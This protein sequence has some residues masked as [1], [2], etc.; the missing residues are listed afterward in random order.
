M[1]P[2]DLRDR[3]AIHQRGQHRP[4]HFQPPAMTQKMRAKLAFDDPAVGAD[5][6]PFDMGRDRVEIAGDK[7]D[8][9]ALNVDVQQINR[10]AAAQIGQGPAVQYLHILASCRFGQRG[11]IGIE[12]RLCPPVRPVFVM[13]RKDRLAGPGTG[14]AVMQAELIGG[15]SVQR[16]RLGRTGQMIGI[17]FD[18]DQVDA[19][20]ARPRSHPHIGDPA[21]PAAARLDDPVGFLPA[22]RRQRNRPQGPGPFGDIRMPVTRDRQPFDDPRACGQHRRIDQRLDPGP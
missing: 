9:C 1:H 8:L 17:A 10:L 11:R 4:V 3:T 19:K 12:Y 15:K 2:V 7:I 16:Q 13:H 20:A 22:F 5:Q 14:N 6:H 18:P 21:A